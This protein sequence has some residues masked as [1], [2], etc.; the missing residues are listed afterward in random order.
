MSVKIE[1]QE[2][3]KVVLEFVVEAAEF[4]KALDI[5]FKQNEKN[6]KLPGFRAGKVPRNV[7]EKQYGEGVLYEDA[8]NIAAEQVYSKAIVDNKLDVV[9]RPEIDVKEIGKGKDLVFTAVV[10]VKPEA[11]VKAYKGLKVEKATVKVTAK[12]VTEEINRVRE[13]SARIE[14]KAKKLADGDIANINFEGFLDGV[15]FEGGKGEEFDLTIGSNQF[16]PGFEEQ[17]I[18]SKAGEEKEI[19]VTFPAEYH[20]K[21]LAGKPTVFKVKINDVKVKQLPKLDD[22]FA[23][24]VSE[25]ETL[26]DYKASVEASLLESKTKLAEREKESKVVD[27]LVEQVEV[28]IPEAMIETEIDK[29]MEDF[30]QNLAAQGFTMDKYLEIINSD[31]DAFRV[32]FREGAIKDIKFNM[33]LEYIKAKEEINVTDEDIDEKIDEL[34]KQYGKES[35][36]FKNNANVRSYVAKNLKSEKVIA[37]LVENSKEVAAK[38]VKDEC[39][40]EDCGCGHNH[41][42]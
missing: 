10:Y 20:S 26:A 38:K 1:K 6:F 39:A 4:D 34:S 40:D 35:E 31:A 7:V 24:D 2:K 14:S 37:F 8:F 42:A 22:E 41:K 27:A 11:K 18:G 17:L 19:N 12:D 13:R 33:A 36:G 9:S 30:S 15:P 16:I 25:F 5:A 3:S 28:E 23:K 29:M 21:D 32:Q